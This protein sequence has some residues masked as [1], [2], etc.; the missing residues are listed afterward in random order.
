MMTTLLARMERRARLAE[1][2]PHARSPAAESFNRDEL[3]KALRLRIAVLAE[4]RY[5]SQAQPTGL[6][7][8]LRARGHYVTL[9]DPQAAC[10]QLGDDRWLSGL[11]LVVARGRSWELLC[12]LSWA[13]TRG[14]PTLNARSSIAAAHNKA[15]MGV[16]LAAARVPMPRT[17]LGPV[18]LLAASIRLSGGSFPIV[19][20]PMFGDNGVGVRMVRDEADIFRKERLIPFM[21]PRGD[22]GPP[23]KGLPIL[24]AVV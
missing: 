22:I 12:L 13:E 8:A 14:I 3:L 20:K 24:R 1:R 23:E 5:L 11:D 15:E 17:F 6:V 9:L 21:D 10:Y 2:I 7:A 16:A 19:L 18:K 4:R